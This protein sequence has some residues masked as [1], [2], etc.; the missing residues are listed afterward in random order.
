MFAASLDVHASVVTRARV[1][2]RGPRARAL[3]R[4]RLRRT[5]PRTAN[6][7]GHRASAKTPRKRGC[8]EKLRGCTFVSAGGPVRFA[9]NPRGPGR[10][11]HRDG[12]R[13]RAVHRARVGHENGTRAASTSPKATVPPATF[14]PDTMVPKFGGVGGRSRGACVASF[15]SAPRTEG[16]WIEDDQAIYPVST[17]PAQ[18]RSSWQHCFI[19]CSNVPLTKTAC[20]NLPNFPI[21]VLLRAASATSKRANA[22]LIAFK[23]SASAGKAAASAHWASSAASNPFRLF[24]K[25]GGIP[26]KPFQKHCRFLSE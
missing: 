14:P 12:E 19:P 6:L 24:F 20:S 22:I 23:S 21:R 8:S 5:K 15:A 1:W 11:G 25:K 9:G 4:S 16:E 26:P 2:C 7:D 3:G 18:T 10:T 17:P 13:A